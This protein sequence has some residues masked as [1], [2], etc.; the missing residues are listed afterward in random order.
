MSDSYQSSTTVLDLD[1][2]G[3]PNASARGLSQSLEPI[4][5]SQNMRRTVNGALL[6]ISAP[7]FRKYMSTITCADQVPPA[8]DGVFPGQTLVVKCAATLSYMVGGSPQRPV[9]PGSERED[10]GFM[11]YRPQLTMKVTGFSTQEDEWGA[12]V[13]W[14][15]QLEE[16]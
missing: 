16:V 1:D 13:S 12:V 9:V 14:S 5:A 15:L 11:I 10:D 2:I 7:Q 4:P 6:D 8:L 3:V